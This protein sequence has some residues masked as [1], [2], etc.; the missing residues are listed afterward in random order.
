M[1]YQ[2]F[3]QSVADIENRASNVCWGPIYDAGPAI[4]LFHLDSRPFSGA[5]KGRNA[6]LMLGGG[7]DADKAIAARVYLDGHAT[8]L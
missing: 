7:E 6:D 8:S 3:N 2:A 5:L 4:I 1:F